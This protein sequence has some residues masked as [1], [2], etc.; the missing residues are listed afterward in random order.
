MVL[1]YIGILIIQFV[2]RLLNGLLFVPT[3]TTFLVDFHHGNRFSRQIRPKTNGSVPPYKAYVNL[4]NAL[5]RLRSRAF[6]ARWRLTP[7]FFPFYHVLK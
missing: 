5:D 4:L 6:D 2:C 1:Y 3:L 7:S